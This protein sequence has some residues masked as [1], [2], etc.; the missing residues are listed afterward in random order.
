MANVTTKP[1]LL[2]PGLQ[3]RVRF[4]PVT[5]NFVR[6]WVTDA[7]L[8]SQ[9]KAQVEANA[10]NRVRITE[11]KELK[12]G[13]A[14]SFEWTFTPDKGG[15]YL[16]AIQEYQKGTDFGG[17]FSDDP[18]ALQKEVEVNAEDTSKT[19]TVCQ[20]LTQRMGTADD[21]ATL[22]VYVSD[23]TIRSTQLEVHGE[24]SPAIIEPTSARD[25]SGH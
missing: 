25:H 18:D 15:K 21:G 20:R 13:G 5:G 19:V 1:A 4:T 14:I 24:K 12:E 17:G 7:P 11:L 6:V 3:C 16:L 2:V 23:D 10:D 22:V 8:G 9:L